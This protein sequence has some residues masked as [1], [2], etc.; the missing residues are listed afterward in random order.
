MQDGQINQTADMLEDDR[1]ELEGK[2]LT[3]WMDK[4]LFGVS[5]ANVE[6]IVSMQ[7]ITEVPDYPAYAK[8]II[9]LRGSIIPVVDLR[10]RLGKQEMTYDDHTCII[11]NN[12]KD[13]QLGFIV[14]EVDAVIDIP[15]SNI[16]PPPQMGED[17]TNRY[18]TG[19]ARISGDDG[20]E[21]IV[22]CLDA[23]KVLREDEL[24]SLSTVLDESA[25]F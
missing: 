15:P 13:S 8:G 12:V 5:I 23:T 2:W 22:L 18:L 1:S 4:Q 21:K 19:V 14:D 11:I 6:Q 20:A 3:F 25:R 9:N 17:V 10:L 16:A 7:P 24:S